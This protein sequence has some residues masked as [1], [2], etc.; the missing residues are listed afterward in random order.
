M[1]SEPL[2]FTGD[3]LSVLRGHGLAFFADR[4]I[5]EAQPPISAKSLAYVESVCPGPIPEAV[6]ELWSVT[7]GGQLDYDLTVT[8]EGRPAAFSWTE[9]FYDGSPGYHD[10][11]EWID[12]Q[13]ELVHEGAAARGLAGRLD[14]LPIGGFEYLERVYVVADPDSPRY[15]SVVAWMSGGPAWT[16]LP[17]TNTATALAPD[18]HS[19]F[20]R[21]RIDSNPIRDGE[22]D[23]KAST[24]VELLGY[25]ESRCEEDGLPRE[26]AERVQDF[27]LRA[28]VA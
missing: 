28:A 2:P 23:V 24:G 18:L 16:G 14:A 26:L 17:G 8:V 4:V 25:L 20:A 11:H 15:G 10:L 7:A 13:V 12:F 1:P 6:R 22:L 5:Y 27:Y 3:E 19:A 21:L 9:L